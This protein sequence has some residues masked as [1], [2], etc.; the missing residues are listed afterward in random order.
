MK[1]AAVFALALMTTAWLGACTSEP[2]GPTV[3]TPVVDEGRITQAKVAG[4]DLPFFTFSG[5]LDPKDAEFVAAR[6]SYS[7]TGDLHNGGKLISPITMD[8]EYVARLH[9][10][11]YISDATHDHDLEVH[12]NQEDSKTAFIWEID[13]KAPGTD[14]VFTATSPLYETDHGDIVS[15]DLAREIKG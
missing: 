14:K 10:L 11:R 6:I 5:R 2:E 1:R 9:Q 4:R 13:Y 15:A 7:I 12:L 8:A 3:K